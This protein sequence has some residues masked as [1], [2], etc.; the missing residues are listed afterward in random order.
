MESNEYDGAFKKKA[1]NR[2][3]RRRQAAQDEDPDSSV[4]TAPAGGAAK[5]SGWG[6]DSPERAGGENGGGEK[7]PGRRR[8]ADDDDDAEEAPTRHNIA[9]MDDDDD[10]APSFIPDLEDEEEDLGRQVAVAPSL[11]TSRVQTIMELDE[12]IDLALPA[13]SEVGVDLSVLQSFLT[14]LEHCQEDDVTWD[15]EHELQTIA[16]EMQREREEREGAVLPGQ[17]SPKRGKAA[18][19]AEES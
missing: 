15:V 10:A 18:K 19:A 12:E 8:A 14:P 2:A 3:P 6:A 7:K 1:P 4:P 17:M 9:S 16:S 5:K 13:S 11:K